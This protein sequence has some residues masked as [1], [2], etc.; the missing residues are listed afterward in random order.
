MQTKLN[1]TELKPWLGEFYA[2]KP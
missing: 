1:L 2:I